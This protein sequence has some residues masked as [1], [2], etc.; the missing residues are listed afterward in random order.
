MDNKKLTDTYKSIFSIVRDVINSVDPEYLEPGLPDGAPIDEY[1]LE[2]APITSF[3]VQNLKD[4]DTNLLTKEIDKVWVQFF[5]N[6][7]ASS[8]EI[9][10]EIIKRIAVFLSVS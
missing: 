2:V 3:L 1:E 7:C 6:S 10:T 5:E 9:A 8:E 4:L